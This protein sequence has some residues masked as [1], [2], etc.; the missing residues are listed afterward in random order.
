MKLHDK[1]YKGQR[2]RAQVVTKYDELCRVMHVK[3]LK[4]D[5]LAKLSNQDLYRLCED[6]YN[7]QSEKAKIRYSRLLGAIPDQH[8]WSFF[9]FIDKLVFVKKARGL[10]A[11][12]LRLESPVRY[13]GFVIR[14]TQR[15][16]AEKEQSQKEEVENLRNNF[17]FK[18]EGKK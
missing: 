10:E 12:I 2:D 3:P 18:V 13:I 5:A 8:P 1:G 11:F 6:T 15:L 9:G 4:P 17:G 7:A 14:R 16:K